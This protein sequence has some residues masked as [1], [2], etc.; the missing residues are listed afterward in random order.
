MRPSTAASQVFIVDDHPMVRELLAELIRC[1]PNLD[2]CGEAGDRKEA[3]QGILKKRPALVLVDYSLKSSQGIDLI[4]DIRDALPATRILVVSMHDE[5][6]YAERCLRAGA[7]G[8]ITKQEATRHIMEA[9][10]VV[11]D[12]EIYTSPAFSKHL[13][14]KSVGKSPAGAESPVS[15]LAD[16]E[17]QVFELMGRGLSTRQIAQSLGIDPKTIDTYRSRIKEKLN[18]ET[19][20][21][22]L[23]KAIAWV[24]ESPR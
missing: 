13:I 15:A 22:L 18:L 2:V 6:L 16:R 24:H 1:E 23:Q 21:D 9:I 12:G 4:K 7:H 19:T 11:L 14:A 10:R 8:Y 17:I 5:S 3:L 20:S